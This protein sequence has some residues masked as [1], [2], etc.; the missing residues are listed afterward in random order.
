MV[1]VA[2]VLALPEGAHV[3]IGDMMVD[4]LH[5]E[6]TELLTTHRTQLE[7]LTQALL[8]A[9]TLDAPAAYAAASVPLPVPEPAALEPEPVVTAQTSP[10]PS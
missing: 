3:G 4:E 6:V 10:A 2:C 5:A 7:S 9:E 1:A 8:V